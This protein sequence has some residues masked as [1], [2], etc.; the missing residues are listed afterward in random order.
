[1]VFAIEDVR[2]PLTFTDSFAPTSSEAEDRT[3][4]SFKSFIRLLMVIVSC[5][6]TRTGLEG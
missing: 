2:I 3:V 4:P 5:T 6:A 1:M